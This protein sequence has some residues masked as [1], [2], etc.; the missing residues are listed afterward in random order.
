MVLEAEFAA[1]QCRAGEA[2]QLEVELRRRRLDHPAH[3]QPRRT[4][5]VAL[6]VDHVAE[7]VVDGVHR[8]Q[9]RGRHAV[10]EHGRGGLGQAGVQIALECLDERA[11]AEEARGSERCAERL[12]GGEVLAGEDAREIEADV[13]EIVGEGVAEGVE[14]GGGD[15][16]GGFQRRSGQGGRQAR[17]AREL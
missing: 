2:H 6:F 7:A 8:H 16:H 12:G 14:G 4:G 10:G 5:V 15:R 13:L 3:P 1:G 17:Q 9:P 11:A